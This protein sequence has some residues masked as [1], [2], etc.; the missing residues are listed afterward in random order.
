MYGLIMLGHYVFVGCIFTAGAILFL[1][2]LF[3]NNR[4]IP[5]DRKFFFYL[6]T[7]SSVIAFMILALAQGK[8]QFSPDRRTVKMIS[9]FDSRIWEAEKKVKKGSI[10]D[11]SG[12]NERALAFSKKGERNIYRRSYP[13]G[14]S[15]SHLIG[16]SSRKRGHAGMEKVF[17]STLTGSYSG[18][19]KNIKRSI[20]NGISFR[21]A[22]GNNIFLTIDSRLQTLAN[23]ALDGRK[24]AVVVLNPNSGEVLVLESSPGFLPESANSDDD[25][26]LLVRRNADSPLF[27]R[28]IGG[29]YPPGSI[30]KLVIAA[31]AIDNDIL[32]EYISGPQGFTLEKTSK[33]IHENEYSVYKRK[34]KNWTGHGKLD[35]EKALQKS[36]N[37][38]FAQL[39]LA[40]GP[41]IVDEYSNKFGFNS[42][43]KWNTSNRSIDEVFEISRS[44]F[45]EPAALSEEELSWSA[46][47]Q[48]KVLVTPLHIALLTASIANGGNIV[49][50]SIELGRFRKIR[51][52]AIKTRTAEQ[53]RSIMRTVVEKGTG[54]RANVPDLNIAGKTGTAET[55]TG[56]PHSWFVSFAPVEDA[57]MVIVVVIE[58]GGYGG[59]AAA[60][61]ARKIYIKAAQL[62]YFNE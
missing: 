50:P 22:P 28:A 20:A 23:K 5:S 62:D 54:Y 41:A 40:L 29:L 51:N 58:N 57:R 27:N 2:S 46:L 53:L 35:I 12:L 3:R 33:T 49:K 6:I 14:E 55:E 32:P 59:V 36:S 16:Y 30:M 21:T 10:F 17:R 42:E 37:V 11:R 44:T 7:G 9:T 24:G 45:P 52:R 13:L 61:V 4:Q 18:Y 25:W 39:I 26:N 1:V 15:A 48:H 34:G 19:I 43:L 31:A 8:Q 56:A 38:Y 47:G 60:E